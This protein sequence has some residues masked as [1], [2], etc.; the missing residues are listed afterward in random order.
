M[1]DKIKIFFAE[2]INVVKG[3][4]TGSRPPLK[5]LRQ[6]RRVIF[7][8]V[9]SLTLIGLLFVYES[10]SFYALRYQGD[11]AYF[12]KKQFLFFIIAFFLFYG[13]LFINLDFLR[14]QSKKALFALI[15]VLA[16]LPFF[17]QKSGGAKRWIEL[18]GFNVQPSELLKIFFLIYCADYCSRKKIFLKNLYYGF[19]P[20]GI[21]LAL[22]C[23]LLL[24]QPDL[25]SAVFW[26][27]WFLLFVYFFGAKIKHLAVIMFGCLVSFFFLIGLYPYRMRR[28]V[29]YFNPF[30]DAQGAGFQ[31]IQS[32]IAYG[33]GGLFGVGLGQ[34]SQKLFFLPAAHTD[35]I[36]SII[37]E[38]LGLI[39]TLGILSMFFVII[40]KMFKISQVIDDK[41]RKG[42]I[43]GS[44]LIFFLEVFI[45]IGVT[46]GLL[47]TK[48]MPLP[49]I[50]YGGTN[51]VVHYL[52]LGL[53]FNASKKV[54]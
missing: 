9:F 15:V 3:V 45:N 47:P 18:G 16:I 49:L 50:S 28:I 23:L 22:I 4:V 39:A 10:S 42:I 31:I 26:I 53:F 13:A 30:A 35:F 29:A 8:L 32:Q 6:E 44:A 37:A 2:K 36:F 41:F 46:C 14:Q 40:H 38:E 11:P 24:I 12:F 34:G 33:R 5:S 7:F 43:F 17:G 21:I 20:M 51:L 52:L 54:S 27:S 19:L 1:R 25:G 48:G